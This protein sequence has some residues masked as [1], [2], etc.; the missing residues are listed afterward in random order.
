M[1][2]GSR[3]AVT[4]SRTPQSVSQTSMRATSLFIHPPFCLNKWKWAE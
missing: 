1:T 2:T 3:S 4:E